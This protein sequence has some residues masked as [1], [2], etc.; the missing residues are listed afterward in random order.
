MRYD[1][2]KICGIEDVQQRQALTAGEN[3]FSCSKCCATSDDPTKLCTPVRAS[4]DLFCK[5][6]S[7]N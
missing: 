3:D 7:G 6:F 5:G 4:E 2:G 1:E